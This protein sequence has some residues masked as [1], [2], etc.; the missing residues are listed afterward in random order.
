MNK[1]IITLVSQANMNSPER[2]I[3]TIDSQGTFSLLP[4]SIL[5]GKEEPC[6]LIALISH[7]K[8][9]LTPQ[10]SKIEMR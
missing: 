3:E 8:S 6:F 2:T 1:V 7:R 10:N 4:S 9:A 5:E